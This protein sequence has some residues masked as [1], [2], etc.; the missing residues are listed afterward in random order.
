M[1]FLCPVICKTGTSGKGFALSTYRLNLQRD[2]GLEGILY[3]VK[4]SPASSIL[5]LRSW[6]VLQSVVLRSCGMNQANPQPGTLGRA[7]AAWTAGGRE[8]TPVWGPCR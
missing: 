3:L 6:S 5:P 4:F 8:C 2:C 1:S 7:R